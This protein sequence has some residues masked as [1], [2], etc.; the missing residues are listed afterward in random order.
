MPNTK[1]TRDRLKVHFQYSKTLY[2]VIIVVAALIG[3]LA[4]TMT[5]YHAPNERRVDIELIGNYADTSTEAVQAAAAQL[6][7]AGQ[8]WERA[9][10]A[11]S[12]ADQE[13]DYELPLQE[14]QFLSLQ[15]DPE[16]S[17]EESYY[18]SQ[19]YMVMLAAQEGDIY[20]L[21][22]SLMVSLV[23]Q[24]TLVPLD[25]YIEAGVIDP[26]ERN[27]GRVTFDA[28]DDDDNATGEQHIFALQADTLTGM[29]DTL[30]FDPTDRYLVIMQFS[31]NQDTAAVL[32]QEM[33]DMFE[34]DEA[35]AA[36]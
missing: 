33:I 31:R 14:V 28:Y 26:G 6:L 29:I 23:E 21:P 9:R 34:P 11:A 20:V 19:K 18:G 32:L 27:L 12:G 16:S 15:Y 4:Y 10:D 5:T 30:S 1:L 25:G 36:Q 7:A 35:E 17:T 24:N 2:L 13:K 8:D 3:N 22:R